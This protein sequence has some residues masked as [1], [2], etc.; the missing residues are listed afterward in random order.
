MIDT[1]IERSAMVP[2]CDENAERAF[3]GSLFFMN[4]AIDVVRPE[5]EIF[6]SSQNQLVAETIVTLWDSGCKAIDA[7]TVGNELART[8]R[9]EDAGGVPYLMTLSEAVPHAEHV[10]YYA[11]IVR[12]KYQRRQLIYKCE[13]VLSEA[14]RPD[15][16]I[17]HIVEHAAKMLQE[18]QIGSQSRLTFNDAWQG[19]FKPPQMRE[20]V[21]EG[22]LR[23][24]EVGNF[25]AST[26]T[27]KSWFALMLL[28]CIATGRDWL[29]R[30]VARGNVLLIDNEL[31]R[32]TIEN[33][34]AAVRFAMQIEQDE[35][36]ERFEYLSCRGDWIS[37]QDLIEGIPAKHPPGSLNMIVIDAKYRLFGNGLEENSNDDQ[38]T[39]HNMIDKFAGVMNCPIVLVHHST[40]GDQSGKA[41]TDIGSGGGSQSRTVDLHMVIR[42]HQQSGFAVLDATLR[43]FVPV[44]PMT[45]RWNWPL[46]TVAHDVEPALPTNAKDTERVSAMQTKVLKYLSEDWISLSRLAERCSTKKDRNPFADIIDELKESGAIEISEN[47]VPPNSRKATTGLRLTSDKMTSDTVQGSLSDVRGLTSDRLPPRQP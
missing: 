25:I 12:E 2:P 27:G 31:H 10:R 47:Y 18:S 1:D 32:E 20:C 40:K 21:I 14:R 7:V 4:S 43:S 16:D 37:I 26:K 6:Y 28:I 42:P 17:Q 30:R 9:L 22:L 8:G 29:G 41:V 3:I 35:H 11:R 13:Q 33:R 44:E 5:P 45:L 34:I 38:T 46:W 19:A 36:K 24:G 23:R 39:F 15:S